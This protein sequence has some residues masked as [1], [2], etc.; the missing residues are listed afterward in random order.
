[1]SKWFNKQFLISFLF[2]VMFIAAVVVNQMDLFKNFSSVPVV[3]AKEVINKDTVITED[4]VWVYQMPKEMVKDGM[5]NDVKDVVGRTTTQVIAAN[6]YLSEPALD[7]SILRPT[8]DKEFFPI[9]DSWLVELQG[10]IRR[11][12]LVNISGIYAGKGK[13]NAVGTP[14]TERIMSSYILEEVPVAYVKGSRNEEV[15][16]INNGNDRLY[17]TQNPSHIQLSLT[18]EEFKK[19]EKLYLDGYR[20]VLSY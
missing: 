18:L 5:F 11:Y 17:G 16:G 4:N 12:D 9:P 8:A 2:F 10:T 20:F 13:E 1:M 19:L 6:Q 14:G 7:H 15:T 3:M